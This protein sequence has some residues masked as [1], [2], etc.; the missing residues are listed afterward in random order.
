MKANTMRL[1]I[2]GKDTTSTHTHN[3]LWLSEYVWV[4]CDKGK[5]LRASSQFL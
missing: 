5:P 3:S 4:F 2:S 1:K